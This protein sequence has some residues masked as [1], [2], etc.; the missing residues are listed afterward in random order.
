[1]KPEEITTEGTYW[2]YC[3]LYSDRIYVREQVDGKWENRSLE[4]LN[5]RRRVVRIKEMMS[6]G[7]IP[8]R[9]VMD[10]EKEWEGECDG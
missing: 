9:I 1:M 2:E 8:T 3:T 7:I 5:P 6:R 4:E 10:D